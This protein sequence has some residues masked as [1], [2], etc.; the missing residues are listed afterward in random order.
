MGHKQRFAHLNIMLKGKAIMISEDGSTKVIEAPLMFTGEAG[1]QKVGVIL[2][3]MIWQNIFP[4]NETDIDKLEE[5]FFDKSDA[6][7]EFEDSFNAKAIES[8]ISDVS[9]YDLIEKS[10]LI[11]K[12]IAELFNSEVS[13]VDTGLPVVRRSN[14]H[15]SG[16]FISYPAPKYSVLA[17]FSVGGMITKLGLKVNH[18]AEPN[19]MLVS[20]GDAVFIVS[21]DYISGCIGGGRGE[22]ITI[23]YRLNPKSKQEVLCLE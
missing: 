4:T 3:D 16:V 13:D 17:P 10:G 5:M 15:G 14:I 19:A 6:W 21:K 7:F 12:M 1:S 23:D 22:E 20:V 18:S 2:E 11:S 9:D 8:R